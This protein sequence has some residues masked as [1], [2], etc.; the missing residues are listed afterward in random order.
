MCVGIPSLE[1]VFLSRHHSLLDAVRSI[2]HYPYDEFPATLEAPV[3]ENNLEHSKNKIK[4][5]KFLKPY[6]VH[7]IR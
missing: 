6:S 7:C 5:M 3:K 2:L 4:C 1:R